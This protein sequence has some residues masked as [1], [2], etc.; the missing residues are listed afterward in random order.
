M[1]LRSVKLLE[2]F[3]FVAQSAE[4][5]CWYQAVA[6]SADGAFLSSDDR[7]KDGAPAVFFAAA[8]MI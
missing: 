4:C 6:G 8:A 7:R 3:L 2:P 5:T 1:T